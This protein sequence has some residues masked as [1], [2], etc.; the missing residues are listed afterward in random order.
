LQQHHFHI[1][2]FWLFLQGRS[3]SCLAYSDTRLFVFNFIPGFLQTIEC[4]RN[5]NDFSEII[6]AKNQPPLA[7]VFIFLPRQ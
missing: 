3:L 7:A 5:F 6:I 1:P 4:L 2:I